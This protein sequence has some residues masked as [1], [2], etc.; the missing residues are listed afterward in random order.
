[1]AR[2]Q[3]LHQAVAHGLGDDRRGGNRVTV[4][5]A[6]D[7]G[8]VRAPRLP[9]RDLA[10]ERRAGASHASCFSA[11]SGTTTPRFSRIRA[12]LPARR[13]RKYSLARRT[14]PLRSSSI[15]A[16]AGECSGKIRSTPTPAEIFPTVKVA[17]IPPP[18]RALHPPSNPCNRPLVSSP[19]RTITRTVSPGSKPVRF[20][21]SPS[22]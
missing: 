9:D 4:R 8:V 13:R 22:R 11:V 18:R 5:V 21:L 10:L 17:L 14:R 6:V 12:A 15:S 20:V 3:Q 7:D 1:M 16:I 19:A 2:R